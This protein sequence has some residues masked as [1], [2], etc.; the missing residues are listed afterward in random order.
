MKPSKI[1]LLLAIILI[2]LNNCD[3]LAEVNS[4]EVQYPSDL[5]IKFTGAFEHNN[6]ENALKSVSNP[7]NLTYTILNTNEVIIRNEQN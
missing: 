1:Y 2:T 5:N 3:K 7:L 4:S 6:L